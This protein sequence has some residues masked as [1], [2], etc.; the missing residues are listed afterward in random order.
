[1]QKTN[2]PTIGGILMILS[3][4]LASLG[5]LNYA[6]GLSNARGFGEGDMPPFVP[7]IIFGIPSVTTI[8]GVFA[9][10]CG[11]LAIQRKRWGWSLAGSIAATVSVLPLGIAAIIL[12][13][14]SRDEFE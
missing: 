4:A 9:L 6:V 7:S 1:M 11:V 5:A 2:K 14:L 10:A 12:I 13:A 8:I 3:G